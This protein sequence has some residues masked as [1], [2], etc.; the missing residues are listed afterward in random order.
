VADQRAS[1][2]DL[3]PLSFF[4]RVEPFRSAVSIVRKVKNLIRSRGV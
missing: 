2:T 3:H 4:D 1:R